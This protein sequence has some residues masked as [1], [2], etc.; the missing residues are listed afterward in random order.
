MT[1]YIKLHLIKSSTKNVLA[2]LFVKNTVGA[3][4]L[5]AER[6]LFAFVLLPLLASRLGISVFGI[7][8]T[9]LSISVI[10]GVVV[11]WGFSQAAV[12]SLANAKNHEKTQIASEVVLA[13][14]TLTFPVAVAVLTIFYLTSPL[15]GHKELGIYAVVTIYAASIS[16]VFLF[17]VEE[18]SLEIGSVLFVVRLLEIV[19]ILVFIKSTDDLNLAIA[20]NLLSICLGVGLG[21]VILIF[22]YRFKINMYPNIGVSRRIVSGFDYAL[23]NIGSSLYGNG[24]IFLL[25]LVSSSEQV[26]LFSLAMTFTRGLCSIITPISQSYSPKISRLYEESYLKAKS[27][28]RKALFLQSLVG[29]A[30]I[31]MTLTLFIYLVPAIYDQQLHEFS[32][33]I[34]IFTPTIFFTLVSS[35]LVIF[36][37]IPMGENRFYRN[38]VLVSSFLGSVCLL[39]FGYFFQSYGAALSITIIEI[40]VCFVIFNHSMRVVKNKMG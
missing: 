4:V 32:K 31:I 16:P 1:K 11:D 25:S 26:G 30:L 8:T 14:F 35:I 2:R 12:H 37:I 20:I 6:G 24:S 15:S 39:F 10:A 17:Q 28:V 27:A 23:A 29:L 38:L 40:I 22:K 18:K 21:W 9:Y 3:Y 34:F 36:V 13:R 33:L 7:F 19:L 5:Q